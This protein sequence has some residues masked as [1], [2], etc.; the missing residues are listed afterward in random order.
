[1]H[2][3]VALSLLTGL[4]LVLPLGGC[5]ADPN[6]PKL[7]KVHGTITYKGKP[8]ES[9]HVVFTPVQGKG[10]DTGQVATGEIASD[11]SYEMTTFNTGDGAILGQHVVTVVVREKGSEKL[12]K[13]KADS[14]IDYVLPKVLSPS[15]YTKVED[16]PLRFTVEA[17]NEP[18]NI[19]LKD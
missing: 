18:F 5:S 19:D 17:K 4:S 1:M 15:K 7:G 16:S 13:P 10:G 2:I 6:K 3:K 9:G 12:G 11:G 8:V 14:T